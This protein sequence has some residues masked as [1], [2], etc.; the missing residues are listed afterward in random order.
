MTFSAISAAACEQSKVQHGKA[1]MLPEPAT[2]SGSFHD[3]F[4]SIKNLQIRLCSVFGSK[5][6]KSQFEIDVG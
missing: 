2:P 4:R 6:R 5:W 3:E 1:R